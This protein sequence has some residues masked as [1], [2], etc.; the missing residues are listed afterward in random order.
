VQ[1]KTK[2]PAEVRWG[3][4]ITWLPRSLEWRK[5]EK[6][7]IG[8]LTQPSRKRNCLFLIGTKR[9]AEKNEKGEK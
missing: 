8:T 3:K 6:K 5:G 4:N 2:A 9:S 7:T 1:L